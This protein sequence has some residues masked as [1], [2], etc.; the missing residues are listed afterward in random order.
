MGFRF[1]TKNAFRNI[2]FGKKQST[3]FFLGIFLSIT[4]VTS[5]SLWSSTAEDVSIRDFMSDIDFEVKVRSYLP[6][7]IPEIQEWLDSDSLVKSTALIHSNLAFFNAEDKNPFYRFWPFDEQDD[8][9]NSVAMTTLLLMRNTSIHRIRAQFEV[10]GDFDLEQNEVLLSRNVANQLSIIY[11][12]TVSPGY[13]LN[14]SICRQSVDFGVY[15][16][17]YQPKHFYNITVS[18][19]YDL[20]PGITMMQTSFSQDFLSN[21]II[22]LTENMLEEDIDQMELNGLTPLLVV[23]VDTD[24]VIEDGVDGIIPRIE[25]LIDRLEVAQSSSLPSILDAPLLDLKQ[26]YNKVNTYTLVLLPAILLG[27]LQSIFTTNIIVEKRRNEIIIFKERGG[28]KL[29]I[30]GSFLL[31]FLILALLAVILAIGVSLIIASLIPGLAWTS[32]TWESFT[33]FFTNYNIKYIPIILIILGILLVTIFY[34]IYKINQILNIEI[35]ERE[36]SWRNRLLKW[37]SISLLLAVTLGTIVVLIIFGL[38]YHASYSDLYN[39]SLEDTE[40]ASVL[41]SIITT[42]IVLLG[43]CIT[44]GL[45]FGLGK[46]KRFLKI[47]GKNN[48]FIRNNLNKSR[49]K[50]TPIIL[51]LLIVGSTTF[52]SFA[53]LS[54]LKENAITTEYYNNGSDLRIN[55][56]NVD[57]TYAENLSKI[58]GIEEVMPIMK[59][60]GKYGYDVVTIYGVN[61]TKFAQIGRWDDSSFNN[62]KVPEIYYSQNYSQWL[63]RLEMN[64]NGTIISEKLAERFD[65]K[66]GSFVK[67]STIPTAGSYSSD[68]YFVCGIMHSAPGLG[69]TS[70]SNLALNQP[71]EYFIMINEMKMHVHYDLNTTNLFFAKTYDNATLADVVNEVQ[72][73]E[74]VYE[75][76]P[77]LINISYGE[78]Y[79][80]RYVPSLSTFIYILIVLINIIGIITVV[81]NIDFILTQRKH[82]NAILFALGNS[83]KNF[84]SMVISELVLVCILSIVI[85]G[86]IGIPL[87]FLVTVLTKPFL[88]EMLVLPMNFIVPYISI[89]LVSLG[90]LI[91]PLLSAI[92]TILKSQREKIAEAIVA[93]I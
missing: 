15:L 29:Q 51:L 56:F 14:L 68:E 76:N 66:L 85:A 37:L 13:V 40:N 39:Y 41:F 46:S 9:N 72:Q 10:E 35:T 90:I 16:F 8:M 3:I 52:F 67:F 5:L 26:T 55:T 49:F 75:V 18:G 6:T 54:T 17:Q 1:Y 19:I 27:I 80:Y 74:N 57:Y 70:G 4:I 82:N 42:L 45:Y 89:A 24:D 84:T 62:E 60:S 48:F 21:S 2:W 36:K 63:R 25:N 91:I 43:V 86:I 12:E 93:V 22:F 53:L 64:V 34:T 73:Q 79:V 71:N 92:P 28:E 65:I 61:A 38:Q 77:E 31:E 83:W 20:I 88:L 50:F 44:V 23:K 47:L 33:Y 78:F 58:E 11:N 7:K 59:T 69:L 81:T 32:L 30:M 87:A